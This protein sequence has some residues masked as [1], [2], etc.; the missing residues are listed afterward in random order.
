MISITPATSDHSQ[1]IAEIGKTS[2]IESHGSSASAADIAAY[3][4]EKYT[5]AAFK[6]ELADANNIYHIIYYNGVAAG[7]SKI[8][9][10]AGHPNIAIENVTKLE[11][12]Y[13]LK[14]FYD[15][16]LG[17]ELLQFN[18]ALATRNKQAGMWLFTWTGNQRAINFY[19]KVGFH[20]IGSHDFKISE[21]HY[22]PNHQMLLTF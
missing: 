4:T 22:N 17:Q 18:I 16:K 5:D 20:I 19:Q 13:L 10:N 8:V 7:Y 11:R 12:L 21:N 9:L 2:F 1:L 15:L 14:E 3:V 6:N